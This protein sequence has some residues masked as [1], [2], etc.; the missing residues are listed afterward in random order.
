MT[1]RDFLAA[2]LR[3]WYVVVLGAVL[4]VGAFAVVQRQ[5]PVFFTQY[6]IVLVGPQGV[7]NGNLLDN[8]LYGLQPM[9]G[10]VA[11]D[12]NAGHG[13]LLTG[14]VVA[15][16]V[17]MGQRDGVQVRVPNLGTQW[18]PAFPAHHLDVQVAGPDAQ[19]VQDA[20]RETVQLVEQVL[21]ERQD[22]RAVHPRLR[23]HAVP[24][25]ADPVVYPMAG[26]RSRALGATGLTGIA[27]TAVVVFWLER[28]RPRRRPAG[29]TAAAPARRP[30]VR[31]RARS[32]EAMA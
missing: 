30:L 25:S 20:A 6:N 10:V 5:A 28:W 12:I 24:S 27:L 32:A 18:R 11:N 9:A 26:S 13:P 8:P 22:E 2:A 16:I 1:A 19:T 21:A 3:R 17:G 4:T 15:T 31:R 14:D 7:R 29:A 23:V